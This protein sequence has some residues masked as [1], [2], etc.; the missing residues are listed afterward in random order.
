VPK[1]KTKRRAIF[2]DKKT[3]KRVKRDTWKRSK[4]HGGTR[5]VRRYIKPKR[6]IS[7]GTLPKKP[8]VG[9]GEIFEWIV[10]FSS[11][12]SGRSFD[13][14]V[15]AR[16]KSEAYAVAIDFLRHDLNGQSIV[17]RTLRKWTVSVAKGRPT[18]VE[19]GNAEYRSK[20]KNRKTK[21]RK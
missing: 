17:K 18:N 8:P 14:I 19:A 9:A 4:A 3:G 6:K 2:L 13:V 21:K 12:K 5:Y 15:T 16:D 1:K 11:Q 10:G 7:G 20:S